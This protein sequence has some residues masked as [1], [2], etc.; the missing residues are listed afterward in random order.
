M[1]E[2]AAWFLYSI[3]VAILLGL[4]AVAAESA[5]RSSGKSGRWAWA[6]A[7]GVSVALPVLA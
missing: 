3:V 1:S 4:A 7:L 5:L 6:G 2:A